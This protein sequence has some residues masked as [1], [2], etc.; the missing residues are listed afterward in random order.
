[1]KASEIVKNRMSGFKRV[2]VLSSIAELDECS[3]KECEDSAG[4]MLVSPIAG[5]VHGLMRSTLS[6]Y[7]SL[8]CQDDN[9]SNENR[10]KENCNRKTARY[11][12][13][14]SNL[15]STI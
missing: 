7:D 5:I 13:I 11:R 15:S 2:S 3:P 4:T 12:G 9:A 6:P 1:M 14:F 10:G 8:Q